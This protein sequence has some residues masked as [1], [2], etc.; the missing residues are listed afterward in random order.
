MFSLPA[1]NATPLDY[2]VELV[3]AHRPI[4]PAGLVWVPRALVA[5]G[6]RLLPVLEQV[7]VLATAPA[8]ERAEKGTYIHIHVQGKMARC[9]QHALRT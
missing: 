5:A 9:Q 1:N 8:L 4:P 7:R 6:R 2:L 3:H